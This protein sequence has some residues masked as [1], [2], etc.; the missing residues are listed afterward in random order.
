MIEIDPRGVFDL[1]EQVC[2]EAVESMDHLHEDHRKQ[3]E[4]NKLALEDA[5]T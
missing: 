4:D 1:C 2:K 3:L 5:L